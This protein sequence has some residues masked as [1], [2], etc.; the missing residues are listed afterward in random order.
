MR[1]GACSPS[2]NA[3]QHSSCFVHRSCPENALAAASELA[4]TSR[5]FVPQG[6][7]G[8]VQLSTTNMNQQLT[9]R[10]EAQDRART[11]RTDNS[12]RVRTKCSPAALQ[13]RRANDELRS[14]R[15]RGRK[16]RVLWTAVR[17][18]RSRKVEQPDLLNAKKAL[19]PIFLRSS[20]L[21]CA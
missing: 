7:S 8:L 14:R 15:T 16:F 9:E 18:V 5:P 13:R 19:T 11:G 2:A 17:S 6:N 21:C 1:T 3:A 10:I 12:Q 20:D 4:T